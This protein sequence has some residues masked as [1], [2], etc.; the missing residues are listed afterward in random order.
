MLV[1]SR[2]LAPGS[3]KSSLEESQNFLKQPACE[4]HQVYKALEILAKENDY[5]QAELYKIRRMS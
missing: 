5:F 3:K 4:L 1:Y 2:I